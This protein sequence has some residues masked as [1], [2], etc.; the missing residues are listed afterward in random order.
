ML[1]EN[2]ASDPS[3]FLVNRRLL[4][5]VEVVVVVVGGGGIIVFV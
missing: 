4:D 2:D 3:D 1:T 5:V